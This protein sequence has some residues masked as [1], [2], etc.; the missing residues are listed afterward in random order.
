MGKRAMCDLIVIESWSNPFKKNFKSQTLV[1]VW[2]IFQVYVWFG[3]NL[4]EMQRKKYI[5]KKKKNKRK[6]NL[7]LKWINYFYKLF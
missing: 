7:D 5:Y 2:H 3:Q 1:L 4:G 6:Y